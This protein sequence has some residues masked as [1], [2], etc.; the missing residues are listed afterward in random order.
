MRIAR[1]FP[2]RPLP[3][4]LQERCPKMLEKSFPSDNKVCWVEVTKG[5]LDIGQYKGLA[6]RD[7]ET[8]ADRVHRGHRGTPVSLERDTG[9][10]AWSTIRS[11]IWP[12][13][14]SSGSRDAACA[15]LRKARPNSTEHGS[16]CSSS[17]SSLNSVRLCSRSADYSHRR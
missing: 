5:P 3:G 11:T 12:T 2:I 7:G 13:G 14:M 4:E 6:L 16:F 8:D 9:V 15:W 10:P 17:S 1:V